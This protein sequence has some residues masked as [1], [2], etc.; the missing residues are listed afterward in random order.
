MFPVHLSYPSKVEI[1]APM[2]DRALNLGHVLYGSKRR[3]ALRLLILV[4]HEL[5]FLENTELTT[6]SRFDP[7][8]TI[9]DRS[10]LG[11]TFRRKS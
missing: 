5:A 3:L 1:H 10:P 4:R 2:H 7:Y 11:A 6:R 8:L 9:V